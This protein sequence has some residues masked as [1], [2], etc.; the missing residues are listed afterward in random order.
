MVH[1]GPDARRA[2]RRARRTRRGGSSARCSS[3]DRAPEIPK[4]PA[5]TYPEWSPTKV[6]KAGA[7]VLY[8]GLPY[9]AS[10]YTQGDV[11]G[12]TGDNGSLSPWKALYRIPGE[13]S[14]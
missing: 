5:G 10:W 1:A 8:Q 3:T 9:Q 14:A 6:F 11:P 13:P 2:E 7:K 4:L 12:G